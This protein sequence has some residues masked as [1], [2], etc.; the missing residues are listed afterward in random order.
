M[1][2][3]L[4]LE[5]SCKTITLVPDYMYQVL[6]LLDCKNTIADIVRFCDIKEQT[7][8]DMLFYALYSYAVRVYKNKATEDFI[9]NN[10]NEITE[11]IGRLI[12]DYNELTDSNYCQ[13]HKEMWYI[14]FYREIIHDVDI[15]KDLDNITLHEDFDKCELKHKS[16]FLNI[17][18]QS[19]LSLEDADFDKLMILNMKL[20]E[21]N[22]FV[23]KQNGEEK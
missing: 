6:N 18:I 10:R 22:S 4:S 13:L 14:S 8:K 17:H 19:L 20:K 9:V 11:Y 5:K 21:I 12:N 23:R 7:D 15:L 3:E 16:L 1:S 2:D